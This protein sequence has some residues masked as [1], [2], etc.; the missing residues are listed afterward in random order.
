[1]TVII[2]YLV[3]SAALRDSR[4]RLHPDCALSVTVRHRS[5]MH[6]DSAIERSSLA[7]R[8]ER[9]RILSRLINALRAA[10]AV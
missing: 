3:V 7:R 1:V 6:I 10:F 2:I 8:A 4:N 9:Q 5:A